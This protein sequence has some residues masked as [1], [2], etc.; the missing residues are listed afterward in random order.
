VRPAELRV[1]NHSRPID[2]SPHGGFVDFV[3]P[4]VPRSDLSARFDY[5][6]GRMRTIE[7]V[8]PEELRMLDNMRRRDVSRRQPANVAPTIEARAPDPNGGL[9][10]ALG[11]IPDRRGGWCLTQMP[12]RVVG[13]TVGS[14]DFDTG[15]IWTLFGPARCLERNVRGRA[16]SVGYTF[17]GGEIARMPGADP[18]PGR[19]ARRTL[20]GTTM[21]YGRAR[22]DVASLTIATPRDVRTL[23]P[24][25][26]AHAFLAVYDGD[27][28]T[29]E[30]VITAHF[31]DGTSREADRF[32]M[33]GM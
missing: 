27:F 32:G 33:G 28:P 5:G 23:V 6:S 29:G 26:R 11:A 30:I 14:I 8:R 3:P 18:A 2:P 24:S 31:K 21:V 10:W 19:I 16:A 22:D 4:D 25:P 1:R 15:R 20:P 12:G 7:M 9:P 13:E 17:G